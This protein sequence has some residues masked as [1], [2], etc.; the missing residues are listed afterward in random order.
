M[1]NAARLEGLAL[2][3]FAALACGL[4]GVSILARLERRALPV[5]GQPQ[6]NT[7]SFQ[8]SPALKDG[9]YCWSAAPVSS[10]YRFQSSPAPKDGRYSP[11][12]TP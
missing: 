4:F 5:P 3:R 11:L 10:S 9:R 8:S 1:P 7:M 12:T 6:L 2:R